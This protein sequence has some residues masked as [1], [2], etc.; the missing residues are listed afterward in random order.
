MNGQATTEAATTLGGLYAIVQQMGGQ[1]PVQIARLE[2]RIVKAFPVKTGV[3]QANK[4]WSRM[5]LTV[6]DDT[7]PECSVKWWDP[8]LPP[9]VQGNPRDIIGRT[10]TIAARNGA[11]GLSGAKM[12]IDSF[13]ST[14]KNCQVTQP[15]IDVNGACMTVQGYGESFPQ[16]ATPPDPQQNL[17]Q[18]PPPPLGPP[19]QSTPLS[20]PASSFG[21]SESEYWGDWDFVFRQALEM[22]ENVVDSKHLATIPS[23]VVLRVAEGVARQAMMGLVKKDWRRDHE[24]PF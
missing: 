2:V 16:G 6:S 14:Q 19:A 17:P 23:E 8:T 5:N 4:E 15:A 12:A 13:W 10:V 1:Q 22:V 9:D 20:R 24:V 18:S 3:S 7:M 21:I 11:K